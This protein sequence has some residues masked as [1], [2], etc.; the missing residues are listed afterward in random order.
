MVKSSKNMSFIIYYVYCLLLYI[1]II[2][3]SIGCQFFTLL[4]FLFP[5]IFFYYY[6]SFYNLLVLNVINS[7]INNI[8]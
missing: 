7:V 5:Y 6:L 4:L 1:N 2:K 3:E 8:F